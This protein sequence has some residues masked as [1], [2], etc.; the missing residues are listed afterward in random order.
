MKQDRDKFLSFYKDSNF[1]RFSQFH[2][3]RDILRIASTMFMAEMELK[4]KGRASKISIPISSQTY[5]RINV[6]FLKKVLTDLFLIILLERIEINIIEIDDWK[7]RVFKKT[8]ERNEHD[9]IILFSGGLDSYAGIEISKLNFKSLLGVFIAHNDQGRI[10][11]IVNTIKPRIHS[12]I[13]TIYAPPMG[14]S[15]YSQL[16]GF[17]YILSG[18]VYLNMS[19]TNRIIVTECGPTMYQTL[20]SP[21]DSITYT[22]HPYVLKAAY[23]C[24]QILLGYEPQIIIPFE[25]LTKAEIVAISG[26]KDFDKLHSCISQRFGDHDGTCFGCVIRR[27][28]CVVNEVRDVKYRKDFFKETQNQDNFLNLVQYSDDILTNYEKMPSFQKEKI[29]EFN[30][31][32]LFRRFALDN[33]AGVMLGVPENH[34]LYKKYVKSKEKTLEKRLDELWSNKIKPNFKRIIK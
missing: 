22:T 33:L 25:N 17:L 32:D 12:I 20:F 14:S 23:D 21:F 4:T 19:E 16:R 18:A 2:F 7:G 29:E 3:E 27:L 26:I 8:P 1:L 6:E 30:K 28:A 13:K 24:L 10:I 15:G 11:K 9:A 34:F 31:H 5:R